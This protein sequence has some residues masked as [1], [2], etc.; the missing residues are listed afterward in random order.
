[1][2]KQLDFWPETLPTPE[3]ALDDR[4]DIYVSLWRGDRSV[5][6]L[7]HLRPII[8]QRIALDTQEAA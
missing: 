5:G 3:K 4:I 8:D 2:A 6:T 1:V 7:R